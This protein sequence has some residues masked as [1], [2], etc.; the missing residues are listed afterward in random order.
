MDAFYC[1][2]MMPTNT[3]YYPRKR[4]KF[5]AEKQVTFDLR[6]KYSF[7][8]KCAWC[9]TK[10]TPEFRRGPRNILL[11]NRCGLRYRKSTFTEKPTSKH[12][13]GYILN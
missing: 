11:C 2:I 3:P 6:K 9:K 8:L 1:N 13:L 12:D 5:A 7:I 4:S 10:E